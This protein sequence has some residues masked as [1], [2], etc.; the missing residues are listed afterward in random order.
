MNR[1]EYDAAFDKALAEITEGAEPTEDQKDDALMK[2]ISDIVDNMGD[3][4]Q[5]FINMLEDIGSKHDY[6]DEDKKE[7]FD[8]LR[9]VFFIFVFNP[10]RRERWI[11]KAIDAKMMK[12]IKDVRTPK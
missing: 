3:V 4:E 6:K 12:A 7:L 2:V 9:D 8:T 1:E 10:D 5:S 11:K